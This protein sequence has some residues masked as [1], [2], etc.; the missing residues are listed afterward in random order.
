[1]VLDRVDR[2]PCPLASDEIAAAAIALGLTGPFFG[3]DKFS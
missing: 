3:F 1:M 2:E